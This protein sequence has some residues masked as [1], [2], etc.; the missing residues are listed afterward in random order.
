MTS[1]ALRSVNDVSYVMRLKHANHFSWQAQYLVRLE[2]DI[3]APHIVNDLSGSI[4][5]DIFG[6][7][8]IKG[9]FSW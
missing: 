9:H 4:V 1:V 7:R 6:G 3:F 2:G 5:R 8:S